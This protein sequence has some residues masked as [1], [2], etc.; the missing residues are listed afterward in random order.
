MGE[1]V[2]FWLE[3]RNC[4]GIKAAEIGDQLLVLYRDRYYVVTGG[5]AQSRGGRPLRYATSSLP[6][7]WKRALKGDLPSAV[8]LPPNIDPDPAQQPR[9][10][11]RKKREK[12]AMPEPELETTAAKSEN[13]PLPPAKNSRKVEAKPVAQAPVVANCPYCNA[14]HEIPVEKGKNGKPFFMPCSRCKS[15][16][17]VRFVQVTV[18]QAQVAGFR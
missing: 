16:F 3:N 4:A 6:T 10:P 11:V 14:R 9:K 18:F 8:A 7:P 13:A 17:A 5:A 1:S 15:D 2:V 12:P